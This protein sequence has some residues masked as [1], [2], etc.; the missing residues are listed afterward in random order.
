M[1]TAAGKREAPTHPPSREQLVHLLYEAAELEHCLLCSYLYAAASLR[2]GTEEGLSPTQAEAVARWHGSLMDVAIQEMGHLAAVSNITVALGATPRFQRPAFPLVPGTLPAGIVVKL[3]PFDAVTLQHFVHVERPHGST[4]PDAAGY[5]ADRGH[6]RHTV[7]HRLTPLPLEHDTVGTFYAAVG[8]RLRQL[9]D[10]QGEA[11]A[12]CGDR[13]LQISASEVRLSG[14]HPVACL[15]SALR[16]FKVIVEQGE[17]APAHVEGSHFQRFEAMRAELQALSAADPGFAPAHPAATDPA[18]RRPAPGDARTWIE[19]GHAVATVD[20]ADACYGQM[21]RFV[22][23]VWAVPGPSPHKAV[24]MQL[25]MGMMQACMAL[26][27]HAA[28]LPAGPSQPGANAGITFAPLRDASPFAP[29]LASWQ[30]FA[31]RVE[32][33]AQA[34]ARLAGGGGGRPQGA[35]QLLA[36]LAARTR[37]VLQDFGRPGPAP[38][39][40]G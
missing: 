39:R 21:V 1:D 34:A 32:E 24:A 28:R 16:A 33:L 4:E 19:D 13:A 29:G 2:A 35:A 37:G 11:V 6:A 36:S 7:A 3:A 30:Y 5:A 26:A 31:E 9:V 17:G 23:H 8:E 27:E 25:A 18:L 38:P 15:A 12:F 10:A 14:A 40:G 20:L 22:A